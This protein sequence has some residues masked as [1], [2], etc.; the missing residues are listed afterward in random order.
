MKTIAI[1]DLA[2]VRISANGAIKDL[3]EP[4]ASLFSDWRFDLNEQRPTCETQ[5][6]TAAL[7]HC[8]TF[9]RLGGRLS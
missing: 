1:G 4:L 2:P 3:G 9:T 7:N 6:L 8:E 5:D